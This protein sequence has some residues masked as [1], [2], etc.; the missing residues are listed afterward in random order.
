MCSK[1]PVGHTKC[2]HWAWCRW[3]HHVLKS[4]KEFYSPQD[5][6]SS[7]GV[8]GHLRAPTALWYT[9]DFSA[10]HGLKPLLSYAEQGWK[11]LIQTF[12]IHL[13][14]LLLDTDSLV[15]MK[16]LVLR[17]FQVIRRPAQLPALHLPR[18]GRLHHD[19]RQSFGQL[20]VLLTWVWEGLVR[21]LGTW[22]S[23]PC[24]GLQ[25][26]SK[27]STHS[28]LAS[29]LH[30]TCTPMST[31]KNPSNWCRATVL[32]REDFKSR[33]IQLCAGQA[34]TWRGYRSQHTLLCTCCP[35]L[36]KEPPL[37]SS[38]SGRQL[39][40]LVWCHMRS[41]NGD[42][43]CYVAK[44]LCFSSGGVL[45]QNVHCS[46]T[47]PNGCCSPSTCCPFTWYDIHV[48]L[49]WQFIKKPPFCR[50]IFL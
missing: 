40:W 3:K 10:W 25:I 11:L 17:R 42:K 14:L 48:F 24:P 26:Q 13:L 33:W 37:L 43:I 29:F 31:K 18:L 30:L 47:K 4:Y 9:S 21:H 34:R 23:K 22:P 35:S 28:T 46:N 39:L 20:G 32:H 1:V 50:A 49:R 2:Q 6:L 19:R 7:A 16:T 36:G 38:V 45:G 5:S 27:E 8:S 44:H 15:T 41:K 12:Q